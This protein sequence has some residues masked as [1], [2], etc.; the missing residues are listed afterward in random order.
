MDPC[1]DG[2]V[3]TGSKLPCLRSRGWTDMLVSRRGVIGGAGA[4]TAMPPDFPRTSVEGDVERSRPPVLV[5]APPWPKYSPAFW[6]DLSVEA[7]TS[8]K[9]DKK[10][11]ERDCAL[12]T[13]SAASEGGR[14]SVFPM[15]SIARPPLSTSLATHRS[16]PTT[17]RGDPRY[18]AAWYERSFILYRHLRT[19]AL[20]HPGD[21]RIGH[22]L[23][24]WSGPR[25]SM[26][27]RRVLW[28][29]TVKG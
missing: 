16:S 13:L 4:I 12:E 19:I 7:R 27:S 8:A 22:S 15:S 14:R 26:R 2:D 9:H 1:L 17:R 23:P 29:I 28:G 25:L 6:S 21:L 10:V 5:T 18:P 11:F 20:A 24:G 3:D